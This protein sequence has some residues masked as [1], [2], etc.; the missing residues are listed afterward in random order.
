M[1]NTLTLG[2]IVPRI[3]EKAQK[4]RDPRQRKIILI[5][6]NIMIRLLE[7]RMKALALEYE[8]EYTEQD[9]V[10]LEV[11]RWSSSPDDSD[12]FELEIKL[13]EGQCRTFQFQYENMEYFLEFINNLPQT[14]KP[15]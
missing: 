3:V 13:K 7:E 9:A 2:E 12:G 4:R 1:N 5:N 11:H 10:H 15:Q 6:K 14:I 8:V